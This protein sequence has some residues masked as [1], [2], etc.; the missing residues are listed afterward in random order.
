M[1]QHHRFRLRRGLRIGE[2]LGE[3]FKRN[4]INEGFQLLTLKIKSD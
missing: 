2:F 1:I 3:L 4:W